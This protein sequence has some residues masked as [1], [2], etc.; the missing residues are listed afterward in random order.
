MEEGESTIKKG[1]DWLT[2]PYQ[3]ANQIVSHWKTIITSDMCV[4][5]LTVVIAEITLSKSNPSGI[6]KSL[7]F[8]LSL[9]AAKSSICPS[10]KWREIIEC[11]L[12]V[13]L[14]VTIIMATSWTKIL[15]SDIRHQAKTDLKHWE[16]NER[17]KWN[18]LV[19]WN[20]LKTFSRK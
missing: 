14:Q 16:R 10:R 1:S 3:R 13:W 7:M 15:T 18:K 12:D 17:G 19:M 11:F 5:K 6:W 20:F 2:V 8:T 9:R 4:R